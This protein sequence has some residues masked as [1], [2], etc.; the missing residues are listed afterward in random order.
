MI[1]IM[2][3]I[4]DSKSVFQFSVIQHTSTIKPETTISSRGI[5]IVFYPTQCPSTWLVFFGNHYS[6]PSGTSKEVYDF[7]KRTGDSGRERIFEQLSLNT[8]VF[9]RG[10]IYLSFSWSFILMVQTE[11]IRFLHFPNSFRGVHPLKHS[12]L[13]WTF[14]RDMKICSG[15][16]FTHIE[17][18]R[19]RPDIQAHTDT[20]RHTQR[21]TE[22]DYGTRLLEKAMGKGCGKMPYAMCKRCTLSPSTCLVILENHLALP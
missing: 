14:L 1:I 20:H 15:F 18:E 4:N 10:R 7:E 8:K 13:F 3:I 9:C 5:V 21:H 12:K 6:L 19:A 11:R 2:I 17:K 16:A 22:T